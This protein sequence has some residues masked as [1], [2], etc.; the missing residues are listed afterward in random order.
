MITVLLDSTAESTVLY[1]Q[2]EPELT[3]MVYNVH[4]TYRYRNR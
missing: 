1:C 3:R 4:S 2:D